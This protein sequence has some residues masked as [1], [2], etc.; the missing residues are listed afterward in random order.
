ME[1]IKTA[2]ARRFSQQRPTRV[3][4]F[5]RPRLVGELICLEPGQSE[6]G[7][8]H[9]ASD[10]VYFVLEGRAS[11]EVGGQV[12][13]LEAQDTILV[14]PGV[15]HGIVN[16]GPGLLTVLSIVGPKPTRAGE[17]RLPRP[18]PVRE[19]R[20]PLPERP[21]AGAGRP[22]VERWPRRGPPRGRPGAPRPAAGGRPVRER[23]LAGAV[24][25][26]GAPRYPRAEGAPAREG[27]PPQ[28]G[29]PRYPRAEGAP[30]REGAAPRGRP[31]VAGRPA[32]PR[33]ERGRRPAGGMG[34]AG[35]RQ[36]GGGRGGGARP[37]PPRSAGRS[38][39]PARG[40][41]GPRTSERR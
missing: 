33:Q 1:V 4:I 38:A 11:I 15:E 30:A 6:H 40:R 24:G 29:A 16:L 22:F 17:V 14:P 26:R 37:R 10:E 28:R 27:A 3:S 12:H 18:A 9:P 36:G 21:E 13:E 8:T 20:P 19:A 25:G 39:P 7:R 32:G 5:D 35:G 41:S 31:G 34:G 23:R 2:A